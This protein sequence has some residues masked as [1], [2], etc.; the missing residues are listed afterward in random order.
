MKKYVVQLADQERE[1]LEGLTSKGNTKARK[2]KRAL[3]LLFS[4]EGDTD[5]QVTRKARVS[6]GTVERVR[7]RFVEEGMEAALSE[8]PR[9]GKA[10]K[11]SGRQEAYLIAL[12]CTEPPQGRRSWP[13]QM[14]AD[15]MVELGI[16]G[17]VSDETV[18]RTLK[19]GM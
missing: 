4:E 18:R 2:L 3:V 10:R 7:Q 13:M 16:V 8:R 12:A 19:R 5:Q 14:L 6:V 15:W 9:P 11:L 1:Q 17:S